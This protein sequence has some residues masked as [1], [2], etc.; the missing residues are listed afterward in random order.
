L[1]DQGLDGR[2][3]PERILGRLAEGVEWLQ[4]AQEN[5]RWRAVVK[6]VMS[7]WVLE[8]RS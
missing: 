5:G 1:E 6:A 4:W 7:L 2:M 8:Q 3:G